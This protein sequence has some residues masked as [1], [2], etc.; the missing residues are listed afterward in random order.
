MSLHRSSLTL[1]SAAAADAL[2]WEADV[3]PALRVGDDIEKV[4]IMAVLAKAAASWCESLTGRALISQ[5]WT[6]RLPC[7]PVYGGRIT[8]P[9]PPLQ[10]I[11]AITYIDTA[12]D[13]QTWSALLWTNDAPAGEKAL[14]GHVWPVFGETYPTTRLEPNAVQVTFVAGY[15]A[16]PASVPAGLRLAMAMV[17]ADKFM[18]RE[19]T[20]AGV[21]SL[22]PEGAAHQAGMYLAEAAGI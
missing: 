6:L 9:N 2:D 14:H 4:W 5:T 8:I 20:V 3:K 10:S 15:G 22:V 13:S 17:V 16:A 18:N 19:T 21:I 1:D 7:F 11:S 12:G